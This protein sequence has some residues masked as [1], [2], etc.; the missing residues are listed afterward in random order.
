MTKKK[1]ATLMVLAG[2][3]ALLGACGGGGGGSKSADELAVN[4]QA[5]GDIDAG[6]F[7]TKIGT[8]GLGDWE[9][10][11]GVAQTGPESMI[12]RWTWAG[13]AYEDRP[14]SFVGLFAGSD[15][16]DSTIPVLPARV[17]GLSRATVDYDIAST[18]TGRDQLAIRWWNVNAVG[19]GWSYQQVAQSVEVVLDDHDGPPVGDLWTFAERVTLS[20]LVFDVYSAPTRYGTAYVFHAAAPALGEH[21]VDILEFGSYMKAKG[22]MTGEEQLAFVDLIHGAWDGEGEVVVRQWRVDVRD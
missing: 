21:R 17:N 7:I 8:E 10:C 14:R 3:G 11:V 16:I 6:I 15:G 22:W 5:S 19:G 12:A 18:H 9:Q 1:L 2:L 4:C 20:G 13:V